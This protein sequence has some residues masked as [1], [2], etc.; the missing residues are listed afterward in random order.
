MDYLFVSRGEFE[1]WIKRGELLEHALVYGDYKG[2]PRSQVGASGTVLCLC[3]YACVRVH[4]C[5]YV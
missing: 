4:S 1:E 2:I 5:F 3:V